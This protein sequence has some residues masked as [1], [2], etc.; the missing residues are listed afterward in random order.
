MRQ[1]P[2]VNTTHKFLVLAQ[3]TNDIGLLW[4]EFIEKTILI[5]MTFS[6][7]FKLIRDAFENDMQ[8]HDL[9]RA[10]VRSLLGIGGRL[11]VIDIIHKDKNTQFKQLLTF[12]ELIEIYMDD[13]EESF[14]RMVIDRFLVFLWNKNIL[15]YPIIKK[16]KNYTRPQSWSVYM[17]ETEVTIFLKNRFNQ[18]NSFGVKAYGINAMFSVACSTNWKKLSDI[19]DNDVFNLEELIY[20]HTSKTNKKENYIT[21]ILNDIRLALIDSGR[22]DIL[23]PKTSIEYRKNY[24]KIRKFNFVNTQEYPNLYYLK[25]KAMNY[26]AVLENDGLAVG[27][28]TGELTSVVHLFK[29]LMNCYPTQEINQALIETMFEPT[30]ELNLYVMLLNKMKSAKSTLNKI[31]KFLVHCEL[32]TIK[33]KT[34][35][36]KGKR[37]VSRKNFRSAMPKEMLKHIVQIIKHRPPLLATKWDRNKVDSSWWEHEVYP[38]YPLMMLFGYYI[39]VRGEQVRYLCRERSFVIN[40]NKVE[41]IIINTDKNVNRKEYQELPCVWED[42][43]IFATFIKWHKQYFKNIPKV[44]YHNDINSP[45]EDI[46]PLFNTP[47]FLEPLSRLTHFNYHKKV[48]CQYQLEIM[49]E[50]KQNGKD[51]YP[52]VAWAKEG[53]TFFKSITE[54]N[55][56]SSDRLKDIEIMYDLHSLRVTGATRYLESGLGINLVM[57][58][59]GHTTPDT[60]LRVYINLSLDEKKEK[61]KSAIENIYFGETENLLENTSDLIKGEFVK[62]HNQGQGKLQ[63]ALKQ[64]DLFSMNRNLPNDSKHTEYVLGIEVSHHPSTWL[65]MIH[66]ICPAVACPDGRENRCSLCPYLITGKL[67]INGITLK[68]NHALAKFQR[69][70]LQ[71]EEEE[72]KGYKNQALAYSL[73]LQLEEILGWWDIMTKINNQLFISKSDTSTD[74]HFLTQQQE[75][76]NAFVYETLDTE[77]AYLANAYESKIFGVEHDRM[78]LKMLTIKAIKI[79]NENKDNAMINNLANNELASID[80]LMSYY[81][82]K[83]LINP[84]FKMFIKSINYQIPQKKITN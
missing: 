49:E 56:C 39:P 51:D 12:E 74:S 4:Y 26:Y 83:E 64:N 3:K 55:R 29:Y 41:T 36:P 78:G 20:K 28:I 81:T 84:Q 34:N 42:L 69:D 43:Q 2:S 71:K 58:L 82:N 79:A 35:M 14:K 75:S 80:Y 27:T 63:E 37:Q 17:D 50:A 8:I 30:N 13:E 54:L 45:W 1:L 73:E 10:N 18:I 65:P 53:K 48:L 68:A 67:F 47:D 72:Q 9:K 32:F 40:N 31:V 52:I 70:S 44:M 6:E 60:L 62:A 61:L 38:V 25:E 57:Q 23:K 21:T 22:D 33:A 19:K 15:Q 59:T 7:H 11:S 46:E 16:V 5:S 66:G 76:K 24:D 77:L